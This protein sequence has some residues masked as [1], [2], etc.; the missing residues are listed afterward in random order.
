M[1]I[2]ADEWDIVQLF[3][4]FLNILYGMYNVFQH[5]LNTYMK[6]KSEG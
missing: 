5:D 1:K 3:V 6:Q 2:L 4:L